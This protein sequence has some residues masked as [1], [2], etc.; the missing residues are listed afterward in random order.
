MEIEWKSSFSDSLRRESDSICSIA[1][2]FGQKVYDL[3]GGSERVKV[4]HLSFPFEM[5]SSLLLGRGMIEIG[6]V[7]FLGK[8]RPG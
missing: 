5:D 1:K 3:V 7:S 4:V 8:T 6:E 2:G